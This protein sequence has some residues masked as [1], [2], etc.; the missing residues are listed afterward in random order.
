MIFY[1]YIELAEFQYNS[2][3][4]LAKADRELLCPQANFG[5]GTFCLYRKKINR[6]IYFY[7]RAASSV[8][9][10]IVSVLINLCLLIKPD[11]GCKL[12]A[13]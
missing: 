11:F 2:H 12:E 1:E 9:N 3:F 4:I 5:L 8:F 7:K 10:R 6:K 13:L